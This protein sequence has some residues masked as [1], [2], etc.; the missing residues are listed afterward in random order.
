MATRQAPTR[1]IVLAAGEGKRM[2]SEKP[3]VL[4]DILGQAILW[5]V[6]DTLD[7]LDLE[8]IHVVIGHGAKEV[9]TY[10]SA[11]SWKTP[12][13][14][15]VQEQQLGTGHAV[16]QVE[17]ALADFDGNI[18]VVYG[19]TPLLTVKTLEGLLDEHVNQKADLSL[20][21]TIVPDPKGYGRILRSPKG[22]ITGIVE[23]KDAS[24][25]EKQ[26]KE[27]NPGM[28]CLRFP[29][30]LPGLHGLSNKNE[31]GEYYLTDLVSWAVGQ[32]KKLASY[33]GE[34]WQ[35]LAGI[36]SRVDL[37]EAAQ[38]L[39]RRTLN[40]LAL[41]SGV[42]IVDPASTWIS[43][44][45]KIGQ[46]TL[47]LP[48]CW[49]IGDITIGRSGVVGPGTTIKGT[50]DVGSGTHIIHSHVE[51]CRVGDN[52]RVGPFANLRAGTV[53]SDE[54]RIGNFVEVKQSFLGLGAK[55]SHLSYLGDTTVGNDANIGAGTIVANYDHITKLKA[56]TS[57]GDRASTGSNS[58]IVAPVSLGDG[59]FVAAGT[60]VTK[61][62]PPGA[63]AV[64]RAQQ[65][66]KEGW[67]ESRKRKHLNQVEGKNSQKAE[68]S[69]K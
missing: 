38:I 13:S 1:A 6:I 34:D 47:I 23:N 20:I 69:G 52:C 55:A 45:V 8:H 2:R 58:V 36:N 63:L 7:R 4:H 68:K 64:G 50:V 56:R 18:L 29:Q 16:L 62:V 10:L 21:T 43:P 59:C 37:A 67:C 31:Q 15:H 25:E 65:V 53:L 39:N 27:I 35:E 46:D 66:H 11:C 19:D 61:N 54:V 60:V 22:P 41:E 42:T 5:R 12:T 57:I 3:K 9:R 14:I 44:E 30:V 28:Y 51:D 33:V 17:K 32:N 40:Q 49:I 26:I 48:N 24:L